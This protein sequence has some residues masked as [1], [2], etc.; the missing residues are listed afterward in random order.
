[1]MR[2]LLHVLAPAAI[3]IALATAC[4]SPGTDPRAPATVPDRA[5]FPPVADL[6]V[7]RCGTLD[8]HGT[9]YRNLRLYGY[10]GLRLAPGDKPSAK[11]NT[12]TA[13]YD[14]DFTS[15]IGLEPE[16]MSEVVASGG[17]NP[18]RLTL[19]RKARGAEDHKGGAQMKEGD[20]QDRCLTS[21]LAGHTD[22]AACTNAKQTTF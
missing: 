10:E 19:V 3:A 2:S 17:A 8:C 11:P 4:S 7:H 12:T 1:M 6:L 21:W 14:E 18:E 16:V 5:S 20:D 13:E 15:V 22:A 9:R